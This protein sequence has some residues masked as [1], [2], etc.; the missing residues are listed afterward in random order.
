MQFVRRSAF[1]LTLAAAAL[2]VVTLPLRTATPATAADTAPSGKTATAVLAGGCFWGMESVFEHVRGVTNVVAGFSGGAAATAHYE[3]VSEGDT[4]HAESIEITYDPARVSYATLLDVYFRVAHDPTEL[5]YQGPDSGTQYRSS[6][7]YAN[8][9]Q[10]R[11]AEHAIAQLTALKVFP[12]P[13]VTKVVPFV[14]FYPAEAYHQ[15]YADLH[16]FDPY[17]VIND[18]PK[19]A[20]L[21]SRYPQLAKI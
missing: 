2:A 16:P 20:A 11:A 8:E 7:F 13:I 14:A 12:A 17:I 3:R 10:K 5:N 6:I 1:A 9:A 4:G 18:A 15:H 19:V 21:K